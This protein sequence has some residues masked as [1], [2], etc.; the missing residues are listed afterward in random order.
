MKKNSILLIIL[1][2]INVGL[3]SG[4]VNNTNDSENIEDN[5]FTL[6]GRITNNYA[7]EIDI[8]YI[9]SAEYYTDWYYSTVDEGT[10]I[11]LSP[12]E[13]KN[14]SCNV[15][16]GYDKYYF[17]V[18]WYYQNGEQGDFVDFNFTN[19]ND[20]DVIYYIEVKSN[21]EMEISENFRPVSQN[22][23]P[24]ASA[25]ADT[26]NGNAP[27]TVPF[28]GSASDE[29]GTIISYYWDFGDGESSNKQN[30]THTFQEVGTYIVRLRI[31]DNEGAT[32]ID[33]ITI[34]VQFPEPE[35]IEQHIYKEGSSYYVSGIIQNVA[36]SAISDI[37][38]EVT[39]YD[40]SNNII[41]KQDYIDI[42]APNIV[43]SQDVACF[44]T[45][46]HADWYHH[47][48]IEITSYEITNQNPDEGL[49]IIGDYL[50]Y[51]MYMGYFIKGT[52]KNTG[53]G[54]FDFLEVVAMLY[55]SSGDFI[56]VES[57]Y[58]GDFYS[59]QEEDFSIGVDEDV[60]SYTLVVGHGI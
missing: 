51:E 18:S 35:I 9:V 43:G 10:T 23:A 1:I 48:G 41:E 57:D 24:E 58:I 55:D 25:A 47:Y 53:S 27:L 42:L 38:L 17:L 54:I 7:E 19:Y 16:K 12:Y 20:N 34:T 6:S 21:T 30:P 45:W 32:G 56:G 46:V 22:K 11:N 33:T 4:C 36:Q 52:V 13:V 8:D 14:Y 31:T 39:F 28:N 5:Y 37:E 44:K 49:E 26:T 2:V 60:S 50:E 29:D 15:K 3:L 59:G 40:A